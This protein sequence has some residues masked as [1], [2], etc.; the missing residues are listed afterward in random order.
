LA[1]G[2]QEGCQVRRQQ[3][4]MGLSSVED[5]RL[6]SFLSRLVSIICYLVQDIQL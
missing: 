3:H 5:E 1:C 2:L 4:Y 6:Q